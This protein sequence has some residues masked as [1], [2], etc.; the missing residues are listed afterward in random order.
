MSFSWLGFAWEH[1]GGLPSH[2]MGAQWVLTILKTWQG[3]EIGNVRLGFPEILVVALKRFQG[4][5]N[6]VCAFTSG[7]RRSA[8]YMV[9]EA[10]LFESKIRIRYA[11]VHLGGLADAIFK[12]KI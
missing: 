9:L 6:R 1:N 12:I 4:R 10:G 2:G 5:H 11:C 7:S 3:G 8:T